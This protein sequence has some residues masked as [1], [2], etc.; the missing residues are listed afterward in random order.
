MA[1]SIRGTLAGLFKLKRPRRFCQAPELAA[2]ARVAMASCCA[3]LA[4]RWLAC[5]R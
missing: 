5:V 4:L 1:A 2:T 3:G